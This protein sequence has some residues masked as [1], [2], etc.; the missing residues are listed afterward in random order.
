MLEI[1]ALMKPTQLNDSSVNDAIDTPAFQIK[2]KD[3][4]RNVL[5]TQGLDLHDLQSHNFKIKGFF[6][7]FFKY[8]RDVTII[9]FI[10]QSSSQQ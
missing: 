8:T 9:S 6:F 2:G 3:T 1:I 7:F 10:N 5:R 4:I